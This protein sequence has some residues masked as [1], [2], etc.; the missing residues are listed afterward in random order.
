VRGGRHHDAFGER[1][2][3]LVPV[4]RVGVSEPREVH[5]EIPQPR[6]H[7]HALGRN[8][9][10]IRRHR[11]AADLPNCRDPLAVDQDHAVGERRAARTVDQP[12]A[13]QRA[14]LSGARMA[15]EA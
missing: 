11:D 15:G 13:D 12:S 10:G 8:H 6:Q 2:V 9:L 1:H 4:L 5:V 3:R 7:R 14:Q